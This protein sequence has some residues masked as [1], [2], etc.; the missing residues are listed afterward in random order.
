MVCERCKLA[1]KAKLDEAGIKYDEIAIGEVTLP[2]KLTAAQHR[3]IFTSLKNLGFELIDN[4]KNALI[5]KLKS[6]ITMLTKSSDG[7]LKISFSDFIGMSLNDNYISLNKLFSEI[8]GI[9]IEKYII[10][11]KVEK[12]KE[13]LGHNTYTIAE[14]ATKMHYDNVTQLSSQ[15]KSIT[16]LTP[17]HFKQLRHICYNPSHN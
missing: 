5:E 1:V 11:Q 6:S 4:K 16:G 17:L 8:E 13:F 2:V 7:E 9:T 12:I 14:I 15:F 3:K 10:N